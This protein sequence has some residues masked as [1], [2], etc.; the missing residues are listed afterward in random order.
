MARFFMAKVQIELKGSDSENK[1]FTDVH[2]HY[3]LA[4][5]DLEQRIQRK[6]GFNDADKMFSSYLDE[7]GWPYQSLIFDPRPYTVILEKAARLIGSK[8]KGRLVPREGG[9]TLGAYVNNELL[10]FQWDDN[11]RLG[12]SMISKWIQM[13]LNSRKYGSSFAIVPWHY[14]TRVDSDAGKRVTFY[15]G[16]DFKV[17][18]PRDVLANPSYSFIKKWFQYREYVTIDELENTNDAARSKPIYK[19]LKE[20]RDS[21]DKAKAVR[22]D[23][24]DSQYTI[25]NKTIKGLTDYMGRDKVYPTIEIVTEYRPD[26]WITFVPR[27][28]VVI[29]DI[30]N[31]YK[32]GE[33]PVIQLKYYPFGDDLYGGSELEPVSRQIR[34][35]NAHVSAYCDRV[36]L[37]LRPPIHVNP[38]NVRMHTLDWSPEAKWLMNTPNVDVQV[39]RMEAGEDSAFQAIYSVLVGSLLSA[40]GESSQGMSSVNPQSDGGRVTATEIKNTAFVRSVRDNMNQIYLSEALKKQIMFWHSMNQQFMFKGSKDEVKIVRIVGKEAIRFFEDKGVGDIRPTAGDMEQVNAGQMDMASI[41]PGPAYP[42]GLPNGEVVPKFQPDDNGEGGNL[43]IEP[44]DLLGG[45]DYV[46]DIETMRAPSEEDVTNKMKELVAAI[47]NP[48][49]LQGLATN[50]R[51]PKFEEIL[52]KLI[53]ANKVVKDADMLF[54]DVKQVAPQIG[55]NG[56]DPTQPGGANPPAAG[57]MGVGNAGNPWMATGGPP[58]APV[59]NP[60]LMG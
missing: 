38:I 27:H 45:Y 30:P 29:R 40:L 53:E 46:P 32:H 51:Q 39:M 8:P 33:I 34:A 52:K 6:N 14:E 47:T 13:D 7:K 49:I 19:N 24:R 60:Q 36:A 37:R 18:N 56:Q 5:E 17:C 28:G 57:P 16:P 1:V 3:T 2:G 21:L 59:A 44:G 9:D 58:M 10:S 55:M 26:R 43:M 25:T 4:K 54:E 23:K 35:I 31:H 41:P 12:E 20:L 22:G 42:V 11:S 48:A 50:G 15:D